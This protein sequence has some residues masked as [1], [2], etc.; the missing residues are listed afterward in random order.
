MGLRSANFGHYP[1]ACRVWMRTMTLAGD[2]GA[3]VRPNHPA[4][5][6]PS[7]FEGVDA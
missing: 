7:D 1:L 6:E 5:D 2:I 4:V 3:Y